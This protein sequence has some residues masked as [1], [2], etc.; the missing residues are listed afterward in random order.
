M[1]FLNE[2]GFI[3]R[4]FA[5]MLVVCLYVGSWYTIFN[6]QSEG[7]MMFCGLGIVGGT[8]ILGFFLIMYL[9]YAFGYSSKESFTSWMSRKL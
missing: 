1:N 2:P 9:I 4:F 3:H 7:V 8:L 6:T 5:L